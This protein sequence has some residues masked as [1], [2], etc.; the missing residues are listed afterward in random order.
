M[1]LDKFVSAYEQSL[2]A[3]NLEAAELQGRISSIER[4]TDVRPGGRLAARLGLYQYQLASLKNKHR[5]AA[6]WISTVVEPIFSILQKRLGQAYIGIF[7]RISDTQATLR[8]FASSQ[9][10]ETGIVLKMT[11]AGLCTEPARELV[12][13]TVE[14]SVIHPARGRQD[15]NVSLDTTISEILSPLFRGQASRL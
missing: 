3:L 2:I 4:R 15:D 6:C 9:C 7:S 1:K 5:A 8:F 11:L 13:L 12:N 10:G 14:R